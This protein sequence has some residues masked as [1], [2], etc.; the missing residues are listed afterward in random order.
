MI[1]PTYDEFGKIKGFSSYLLRIFR[2]NRGCV[3][4][5]VYTDK[6]F[7]V[8]RGI[9]AGVVGREGESMALIKLYISTP[10]PNDK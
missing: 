7:G 3:S 1:F 5:G 4:K 6:R 2:Y 10:V 9:G 8:A